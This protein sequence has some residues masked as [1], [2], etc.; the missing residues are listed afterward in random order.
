MG[1]KDYSLNA[2]D[3]TEINGINIA[4]GCPPSGINNAIRQLMADV[5]ADSDAQNEAL[6]I[7]SETPASAEDL[8]P[9]KVGDGLKMG[10]DG[11]LSL[12]LVDAVDSTSTTQAATANAV[13]MAYDKAMEAINML[14]VGSLIPSFAASMTGCLL[15][16]GAAVS[17]TTYA[18]L[19]AL[20]GTAFGEGD[21]STTFNLPD[22]RNKTLWGAND[23]LMAILAAGLPNITGNV[24]PITYVGASD[25]TPI[26]GDGAFETV[27]YRSISIGK[28]DY[29]GTGYYPYANFNA[30]RSSTIYGKSTTVQPP[31]IAVNIFI[32]Y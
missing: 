25:G 29:F 22:F 8:G 18:N 24:F 2:D 11:T 6:K 28:A 1:V 31:A 7:F 26:G 14:P 27:T 23:N 17:R 19:F 10:E 12:D 9:V 20:L 5:K 15:G 4:E 30:S 32:K 3:N 16:N 13:K 21:G